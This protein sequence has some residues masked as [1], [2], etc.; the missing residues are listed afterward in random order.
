MTYQERFEAFTEELSKLSNK[1]G[2]LIASV[3][4]V[5]IFEEGELLEVKY[6]NDSTS[7]D[8]HPYNYKVVNK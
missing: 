8:L 2:I 7:G 3:G 4:G 6:S 5:N 1:Y